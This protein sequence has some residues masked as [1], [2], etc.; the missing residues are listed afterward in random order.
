MNLLPVIT[1]PTRIT[2]T[3]A[4][5]IDNIFISSGLQHDYN[6]GLIISD[7]SDHFPTLVKLSNVKQ[8]MKQH[9]VLTYRNINESNIQ[10]MNDDLKGYNWEDQLKNTGTEVAF[11]ILHGIV[12]ECMDKY[13]PTI[14]RKKTKKIRV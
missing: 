6:P 10:A 13:M 9:H 12:L 14:K 5:L 8:D 4:T 3:S 11:H 1:K 2:D 7:M